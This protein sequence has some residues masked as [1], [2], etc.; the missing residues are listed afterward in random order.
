MDG[1]ASIRAIRKISPEAK[2]VA[3]SGLA[4]EDKL[5]KI[6]YSTDYGCKFII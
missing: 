1:H 6:E 5:A 4:E 3:V 2:I